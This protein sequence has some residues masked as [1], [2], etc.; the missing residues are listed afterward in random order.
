MVPDD[1][2]ESESMRTFVVECYW[3]GMLEEDARNIL[4]RVIQLGGK[5][6]P[7]RSVGSL[8][9]VLVPGDGMALFLLTAPS[10]DIVRRV[11]QV[12]EVPFDRIVE[13][14]LVGFGQQPT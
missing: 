11:G 6:S 8:G 4:D 12:A 1:H 2:S 7:G 5:A 10:E 14:V 9:C 13:S 3:P